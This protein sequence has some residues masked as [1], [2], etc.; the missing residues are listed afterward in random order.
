M[1]LRRYRRAMLTTNEDTSNS[2]HAYP[3]YWAPSSI[4]GK[5]G[6]HLL[7]AFGRR[8]WNRGVRRVRNDQ[9]TAE[10]VEVSLR[11]A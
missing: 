7:Y 6:A 3:D 10:I 4:V 9:L 1:A 8:R 2:W 5:E 11:R